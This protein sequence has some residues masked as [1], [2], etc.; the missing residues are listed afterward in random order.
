[1]KTTKP[2]KFGK[3][4]AQIKK[5]IEDSW[6][7]QDFLKRYRT[8]FVFRGLSDKNYKLATALHRS[9]SKSLLK[10]EQFSLRNFKKYAH[11]DVVH[12]DTDWHWLS[13]AQ[14]HGLPTRLLDW[15]N[16]PLVALH[17]ATCELDHFDKDGAICAV[18]LE[19]AKNYLPASL[20]KL[21]H[22]A[23]ACTINELNDGLQASGVKNLGQLEKKFK[24]DFMLFFEP[25]AMD[26]RIVN[27]Y[28][29]LSI[30]PHIKKTPE[31]WLNMHTGIWQKIEIPKE[32][33]GTI[34]DILDMFNA[35]ERVLFPGL[36]GLTQYLKRYYGPSTH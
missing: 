23:I 33:K 3:W 19:K 18:N 5:L 10:A 6:R 12:R 16:S 36:D 30:M 31:E 29:V 35:T 17:F 14:H 28:A 7:D 24:E 9:G 11:G 21:L 25:P 4:F 32:D 2:I 26:G 1:M 8:R 20:K 15:T 13:I 27:Q 22:S 34:R